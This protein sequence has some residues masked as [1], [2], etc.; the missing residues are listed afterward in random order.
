MHISRVNKTYETR[1]VHFP[2]DSAGNTVSQGFLV[3]E[4]LNG[5]FSSV[6]TRG[7]ISSF[8]IIN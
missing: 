1:L 8:N 2:D 4:D 6:L 7:D 3:A 5:Y